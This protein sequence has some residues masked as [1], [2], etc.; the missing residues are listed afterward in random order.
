M[1]MSVAFPTCPKCAKNANKCYHK[2]CPKG[3]RTPMQIDSDTSDVRC[4]DCGKSWKI[5][6]SEYYCSCGYVFSA[7]DVSLELDAII[8]NAKLI[9]SEIERTKL[10]KERIQ[11][12]TDREISRKA[13]DTIKRIGGERVWNMIKNVLPTIVEI[14]KKWLFGGK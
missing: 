2:N 5:K 10:T 12:M 1:W 9:A 8:S 6:E 3:G 4:L 11:A 14:I 7:R 13:T